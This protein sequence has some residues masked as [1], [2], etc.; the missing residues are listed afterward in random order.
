MNIGISTW[1]AMQA[2]SPNLTVDVH[3]LERIQRLTTRKDYDGWVDVFKEIIYDSFKGSLDLDPSSNLVPPMRPGLRRHSF[4]FLQG[5]NWCTLSVR[6]VKYW[7]RL[8]HFFSYCP[9]RKLS[10]TPITFGVVWLE[11]D[12][13]HWM[14]TYWGQDNY[15]TLPGAALGCYLRRLLRIRTLL[16][17]QNAEL[18]YYP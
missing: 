1:R 16:V 17:G 10:R 5:P 4:K 11:D 12:Q 3:H 15:T 14:G 2:C 7:N 8:P 13:H 6:V 18:G 9:D